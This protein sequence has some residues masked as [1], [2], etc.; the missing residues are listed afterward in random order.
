M[1]LN[2]LRL[3]EVGKPAVLTLKNI[4]SHKLDDF[5]YFGLHV[6]RSC[7][8]FKNMLPDLLLTAGLFVGGL[9]LNPKIPI[10]GSKPTIW[11]E[12]LNENFIK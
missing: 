12:L 8:E 5:K 6:F 9:G 1:T 10:F 7:D 2:I 4:N 3:D 11:Q